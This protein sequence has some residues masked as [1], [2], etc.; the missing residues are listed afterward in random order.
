ML[1]ISKG[2]KIPARIRH[3]HSFVR[4]FIID[5]NNYLSYVNAFSLREQSE[6]G[7]PHQRSS[8]EIGGA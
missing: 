7:R 3:V 2:W 8:A 4:L 5:L 6:P 1:T